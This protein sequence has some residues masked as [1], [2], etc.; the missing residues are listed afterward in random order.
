MS[1]SS[2]KMVLF[3]A[4]RYSMQRLSVGASGLSDTPIMAYQLQQNALIP[5]LARSVVINLGYNSAKDLFANPKGRE[6]EIIRVCCAIKS[7]STWNFER[8]S[9]V[10]RERCGGGG[11]TAHARIGEGIV[12]AHSAMTAEGDNRVLMQ[13]IV[14]DILADIQK[15]IHKTPK[16]TKCPKRQ[17]PSQDSVTDLTTLVNLVYYREVAETQAMTKALQQKIMTEEKKFYD[18]WMYEVS[19]QIQAMALAYSERFVLEAAMSKF[20]DLTVGLSDVGARTILTKVVR[21]HCLTYVKEN[22][23]WYLMNSVINAKAAQGVDADYQQAVRDLLPHI[24]EILEA[25]NFPNIPQLA[26]PIVRDYVKFN[27]Q[28]DPDNVN[29]ADGFFDFRKIAGPKL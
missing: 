11:Y 3:V 21:L 12:G 16:L 15:D 28:S 20:H 7:L 6:N 4:F 27:E 8:V 25:F 13:K 26:P 10:C 24:N 18:V 2:T 1:L 17:I 9:T 23:G 14:K 22:L 29:A 5:L 19:D